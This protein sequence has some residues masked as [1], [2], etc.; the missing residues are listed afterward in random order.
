MTDFDPTNK[1]VGDAYA[2]GL[3]DGKR[4]AAQHLFD[5]LVDAGISNGDWN[6]GD[7]VEVVDQWLTYQ[8]VETTLDESDDDE[9]ALMHVVPSTVAARMLVTYGHADLAAAESVLAVLAALPGPTVLSESDNKI[10]LLTHV[11]E[12]VWGYRYVAK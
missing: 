12:G 6:G 7:V 10:L 5:L 11:G 4:Q 2:R 3:A 9:D 1:S 8:G